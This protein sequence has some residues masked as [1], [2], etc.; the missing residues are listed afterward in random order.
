MRAGDSERLNKGKSA[1]F[2]MA[3]LKQVLMQLPSGA[4]VPTAEP[5]GWSGSQDQK[6]LVD[7]K[8]Q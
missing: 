1:P 7:T 6:A 4:A 8:A 2:K 3:G 5:R